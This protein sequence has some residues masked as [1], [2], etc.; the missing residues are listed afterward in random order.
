VLTGALFGPLLW[1]FVTVNNFYPVPVWSLFSDAPQQGEGRVYYVLRGQTL[2]GEWMDIPPIRITDGLT[3]RIHMMVYYTVSNASFFL[4]SPHP[5]NV[6][7]ATAAG[8]AKRLTPGARLPELL[9][10]W[11]ESF[12]ASLPKDSPRRLQ[13]MRLDQYRWNGEQFKNYHEFVTFWMVEL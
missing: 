4:D 1:A 7:R 9:R 2:G 10:S 3:G 12:N 5:D 13:A 11:G 8:G 6:A